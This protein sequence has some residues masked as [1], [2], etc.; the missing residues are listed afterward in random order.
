M[1]SKLISMDCT[2]CANENNLV[3]NIQLDS[4]FEVFL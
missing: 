4:F 1:D 2:E 3:Q